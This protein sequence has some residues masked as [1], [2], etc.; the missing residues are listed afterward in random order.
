METSEVVVSQPKQPATIKSLFAQDNVKK[1][2]EEM[3]GK[4]AQGF[5]TSVLQVVSS[6]TLLEK[7]DAMSIYNAAATAATLDLPIN[8]SLGFSWIVPY[9]GKAQ[10]Q[11]GVKGIIQL[12]QRT[13]QYLRI[14]VVEVY[15]NQFESYN[16]LT[17][18]LKADFSKEG[19]GEI[20]G[21][22]AYFK[23]VNGFEKTSFWRMKKVM[24]HGKKYSKTFGNGPWKTE[25]D[26]MAK[27][28]VLKNTLSAWGILSIEMQKAIVVD[29]A[30]INN[31]EGTD[32]TYVDHEE[33]KEAEITKEDLALLFD[34]KKGSMDAKEI[35]EAE[36]II[37]GNEK[38][39]FPKLNK[40]LK[41]L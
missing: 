37:N 25:F 2:F 18:E 16:E 24:E 3:L 33:V 39:S 34:M 36:R 10:Y 29:Q 23:L 12:A 13:G 22:A 21:Y 9:G 26:K 11:I 6:N 15:K 8:Q 20:V 5:I 38:N 35:T 31:D 28:T 30:V 7:A 19:V 1:K 41:S 17:E 14:N 32:V 4:K 40:K 27:K